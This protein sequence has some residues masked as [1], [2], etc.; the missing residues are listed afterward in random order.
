MEH[1]KKTVLK[2]EMFCE[3]KKELKEPEE[4]S[5]PEINRDIKTI[6]NWHSENSP[7]REMNVNLIGKFIDNGK[8][9]GYIQRIE[10]TT[11]F[12]DSIV[13]PLGVV[14]LSIKDAVKGYKPEK[15][16]KVVKIADFS[17]TGPNNKT[18]AK[19]IK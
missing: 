8:V 16:N 1:I 15:D 10:G 2:F 14:K 13:E 19:K 7:K 5:V 18:D 6:A 11:V 17:I 12:V 3:S 4:K 9:K